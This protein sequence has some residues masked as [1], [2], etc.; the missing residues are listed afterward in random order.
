MFVEAWDKLSVS[1]LVFLQKSYIMPCLQVIYNVFVQFFLPL[2]LFYFSSCIPS[3]CENIV[4]FRFGGV[5][6]PV[7]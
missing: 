7:F 6:L 2:S 5:F 4:F 3:L 1:S